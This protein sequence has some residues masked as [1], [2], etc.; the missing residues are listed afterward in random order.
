MLLLTHLGAVTPSQFSEIK[1]GDIVLDLGSGAGIDLILAAQKVGP[2]VK[3][4]G[5]DMNR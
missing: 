1:E 4:I 3:S 5:I 2:K